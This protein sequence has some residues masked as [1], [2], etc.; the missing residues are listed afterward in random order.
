M[1]HK[2]TKAQFFKARVFEL[3]AR[4]E[5]CTCVSECSTFHSRIESQLL[6]IMNDY[7][8]PSISISKKRYLTVINQRAKRINDS[9]FV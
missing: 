2:I 7:L 5:Q 4:R 1:R 8:R 6:R 3:I 9:V